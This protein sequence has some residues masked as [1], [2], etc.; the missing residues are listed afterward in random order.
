MKGV[1]KADPIFYPIVLQGLF[2]KSCDIHN[3][4]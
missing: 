1:N 4:H 2:N 3:V